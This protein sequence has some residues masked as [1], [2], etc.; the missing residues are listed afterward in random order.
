MAYAE[1]TKKQLT[2]K[3]KKERQQ[4]QKQLNET[5]KNEKLQQLENLSKIQIAKILN[6]KKETEIRGRDKELIKELRKKMKKNREEIMK[7]HGMDTNDT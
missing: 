7:E 2:T 1:K 4:K 5:R 6:G 3:E